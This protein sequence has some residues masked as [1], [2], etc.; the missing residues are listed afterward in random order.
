MPITLLPRQAAPELELETVAHGTWKLSERSPKA[1]TLLI[2]YRGLHCPICSK[3]V[4]EFAS[5]L[6]EF[7]ER[8][9]EVLAVSADDQE[10]AEKAASEWELS[11]I[12]VAYGLTQAQMAAWGLYVSAAIKETETPIF[13]EPAAFLISPEGTVNLAAVLSAPFVRPALDDLLQAVDM[14]EKG[15]PAR[16]ELDAASRA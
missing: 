3:Y 1:F 2:F 9:V 14:A 10:R 13:A 11:A 7:S 5:R 15:Y 6:A 12:P 8:G 4:P 16:G